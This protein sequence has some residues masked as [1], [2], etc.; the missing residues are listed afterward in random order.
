MKRALVISCGVSVVFTTLAFAHIV[1]HNTMHMVTEHRAK[2]IFVAAHTSVAVV[3]AAFSLT[4]AYFL[5]TGGRG[6]G[7]Q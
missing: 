1:F 4:G 5:F 6:S 3:I 2:L 7:P